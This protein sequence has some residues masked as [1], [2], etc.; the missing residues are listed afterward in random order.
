MTNI[1]RASLMLQF[2]KKAPDR[3]RRDYFRRMALKFLAGS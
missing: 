1:Q 3:K 2:S